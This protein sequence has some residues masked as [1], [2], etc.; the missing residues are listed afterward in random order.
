MLCCFDFT[1]NE[2]QHLYLSVWFS[3]DMTTSVCFLVTSLLASDGA[4]LTEGVKIP[5]H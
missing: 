1:A 4:C 2:L 3:D 5:A